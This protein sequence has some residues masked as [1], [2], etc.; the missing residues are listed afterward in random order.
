VAGRDRGRLWRR[1][2]LV[3]LA[4]AAAVAVTVATG[5]ATGVK[6]TF[7]ATDSPDPVTAGFAQS[8]TYQAK[9]TGKATLTHAT[10]IDQLPLGATFVSATATVQGGS[11]SR[12]LA[13]VS[14]PT[15]SHAGGTV[16]CS[17][18]NL[19][20]GQTATVVM[21]FNAPAASFENCAIFTF[22]ERDNDRNRGRV[23]TLTTCQTAIVRSATD[24]NFK[25]G[26]IGGT[27]TI[28]TGSNATA[29]DKQNT[30]LTTPNAACLKVEEVA[31]TGPNDAC[32]TGFTCKTEVSEIEHPPC[33]VNNPCLVKITFD[34]SFGTVT[35][36][37][38]NGVLVQPCTTPGVASPDPCLVSIVL[39]PSTGRVPLTGNGKDTQFTILSAV[40]A[41]LRGG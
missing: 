33:P 27:Q 21:F 34:K 2:A 22:K 36:L 14:G 26:C 32:G 28:S 37:F 12:G 25:G 15:C 4:A 39:I 24:P 18:G 40:D 8:V 20:K 35:K 1:A 29:T 13:A 10:I 11:S 23:D 16:T 9:N 17:L 30:S 6:A 38:Y 19:K 3:A 41:R 7:T 31:A 5:S